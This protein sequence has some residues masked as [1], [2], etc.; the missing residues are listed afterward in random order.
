MLYGTEVHKALEEYV[1]QGTPLPL[2]YQRF[3]SVADSLMQIP[4][5]RFV[6]MQLALDKNKIPCEFN[7]DE[8]WVRGIADLVIIDGKTAYL[9][10]YKTG[11]DRYADT[12][13]L[14][15]LSLLLFAHF[16]EIEKI[17][18]GLLFLLRNKMVSEEY[19]RQDIPRLWE[20]L[21]ND[22]KRIDYSYEKNHWHP[23]PGPLCRYCPVRTCEFN[24]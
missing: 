2:N 15:I 5:H 22:L 4:G 6:E 11:S 1:S 9:L 17:R 13:Q 24:E 16:P 7:S 3:K 12:K 14:D 20:K 19:S 21:N 23:N 8:K 18:A 10:D